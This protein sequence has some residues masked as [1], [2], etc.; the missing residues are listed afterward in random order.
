M[1]ENASKKKET[2]KA[3]GDP[4]DSMSIEMMA[5]QRQMARGG[6]VGFSGHSLPMSPKTPETPSKKPPSR[7]S[8][9]R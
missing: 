6:R 8:H 9:K 2:W 3:W 5:K 4:D 1:N 7:K